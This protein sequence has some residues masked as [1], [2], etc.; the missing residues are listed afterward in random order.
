LSQRS[1]RQNQSTLARVEELFAAKNG[2]CAGDELELLLLLVETYEKAK[3][4]ID[5]PDPIEAI[6]FR[7]EQASQRA[8]YS[9]G[10]FVARNDC[11][12]RQSQ[13]RIQVHEVSIKK[14]KPHRTGFVKKLISVRA[15]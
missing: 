13:L 1:S 12:T 11:K 8:W 9:N 14:Q 7:M 2:T 15:E 4:L 6:R 5:L 10:C 3:F